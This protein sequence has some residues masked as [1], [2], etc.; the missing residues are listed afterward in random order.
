[1]VKRVSVL[2]LGSSGGG[3]F[4][5]CGIPTAHPFVGVG[6]DKFGHMSRE[7]LPLTWRDRSARRRRGERR[8][9]AGHG[10][11]PAIDLNECRHVVPPNPGSWD[12]PCRVRT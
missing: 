12:R 7:L 2:R 3:A 10:V 8:R 1:M 9:T 11:A 5:V 6:L 4:V